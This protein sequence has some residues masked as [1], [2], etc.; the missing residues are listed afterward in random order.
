MM[1]ND[2]FLRIDL[3]RKAVQKSAEFRKGSCITRPRRLLLRPA[4]R[5]SCPRVRSAPTSSMTCVSPPP[6]PRA[7]LTCRMRIA[8]FEIGEQF[9]LADRGCS[10][11]TDHDAGGVVRQD[12][13][14]FH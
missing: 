12:R 10:H 3:N 13:R 8:G 2:S 1:S 4:T 7:E 11:L 14:L 6:R 5:T 9:G